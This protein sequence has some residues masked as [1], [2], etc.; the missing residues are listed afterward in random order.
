MD[1]TRWAGLGL[2][3]L[4]GAV[5]R[6]GG[7]S[8]V[9]TVGGQ[10]LHYLEVPGRAPGPTLVLVHGLGGSAFG[11]LRV[12]FRFGRGVG[13]VVALDLPGS[14]LSPL[15]AGGPLGFDGVQAALEA[16]AAEVVPE[17]AVYLGNSLGGAMV[18]RLSARHPQAVAGTVLVAP[19][20]G[21]VDPQRLERL[22]STFQ[23]R[24]QRDARD[25]AR[26]FFSRPPRLLPF[27]M[28]PTL[29]PMMQ[30]PSVRKLL[31]EA[32]RVSALGEAELSSLAG[33]LLLLWAR[34]ERVLPY[35]SLDHFRAHLPASAQIEEVADFGHSPQLDR[36]ARLVE[37]VLRF[38]REQVPAQR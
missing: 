12:L 14:G 17:P 23:V 25:L 36:P 30:R 33:P 18:A 4:R 20:G 38:V 6:Q 2:R 35:E 34:N 8:L 15:P 22:L 29:L 11:W 19:G 32:L 7:R 5:R 9:R 31:E 16:F 27:L 26:R 3:V 24:T 21:R 13:R 10:P 28:A 1:E 37:R